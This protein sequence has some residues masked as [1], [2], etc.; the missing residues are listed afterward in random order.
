VARAITATLAANGKTYDGTTAA[1]GTLSLG[2]VLG[3]DQVGVAGNLGFADKNA[4]A[5]KTVT[6]SGITLS[7][8]DAGNYTVNLTATALADIVAR[9]ITATL[10]ANGKTYD[11]TTAATGT[12]SLNGVVAGD[13]VGANGSF[14][15][16]DKNAGNGK[17]V[18][19]SGI[20]LSGADA[21]NY[22]VNTTATALADILARAITAALVANGKTY[23]GTTAAT[24]TLSLN[25]VVAGDQVGV[26]GNLAFADK[27]AGAGKTVTASGIT[28]SGADAGNYT[29]SATATAFA[30]ILVRAITA[31]AAADSRVYDGTAS[32]TGR[33]TLNGVLAGDTVSASASY[34]FAD[35]NAGAGRIVSVNGLTL[36]GAD[37]G[38]YTVALSPNPVVADILRRAV[39]VAVDDFAKLYGQRDPAFTWRIVSGSLVGGDAFTGALERAPGEQ[40]GT[41][42]VGRGSLALSPNYALTLIP[43]SLTIRFTQSGADSTDALKRRNGSTGF[44]LYEDPSVGLKGDTEGEE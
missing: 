34:V 1:T 24:G 16:A 15:F 43:G 29:V 8:T 23:D 42:L 20:T 37:A 19:A 5:G 14:A 25:G 35:P 26:G 13:Q 18:S 27:N 6:A 11:G 38:N 3:G 31:T 28:L 21:G 40:A 39:T 17:T 7:G 4:G 33:I 10:A 44:S 12:L 22:T 30:D 2:G 9:A 36:S 41:Y 32:T